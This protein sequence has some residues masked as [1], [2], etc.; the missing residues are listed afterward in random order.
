AACSER[1]P[2]DRGAVCTRAACRLGE[3]TKAKAW[4]GKVTAAKRKDVTAAC[5]QNGIDLAP[6]VRQPK[7]D[8]GVVDCLKEPLACQN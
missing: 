7:P 5:K 3:A 2:G 4:F 1:V 8:A 6:P